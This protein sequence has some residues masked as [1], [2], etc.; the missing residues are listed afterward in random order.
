MA[1]GR[2]VRSSLRLVGGP[3]SGLTGDPQGHLEDVP[4]ELTF[5]HVP[6]RTLRPLLARKGD[7]REAF[8]GPVAHREENI[9]N[10]PV[11]TK[12]LLQVLP[13]HVLRQPLDADLVIA[14]LRGRRWGAKAIGGRRGRPLLA[15]RS[16]GGTR[17]IPKD[18]SI[19]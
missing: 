12:D 4:V 5:V 10:L 19:E 15:P 2:G 9:H 3:P 14:G 17:R 11:H 18:G 13:R 8:V 6:D 16:P 7:V 1:T